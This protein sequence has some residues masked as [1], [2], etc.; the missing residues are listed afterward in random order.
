MSRRY[1][2][3]SSLWSLFYFLFSLIPT[4]HVFCQIPILLSFSLAPSVLPSISGFY[5]LPL[6]LALFYPVL[7]VLQFSLMSILSGLNCTSPPRSPCSLPSNMSAPQ[8]HHPHSLC[9]T[10]FTTTAS[11]QMLPSYG[12]NLLPFLIISDGHF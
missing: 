11:L 6:F 4:L 1:S 5:F 3:P 9:Y 8:P 10:F 2:D 7:V 12:T